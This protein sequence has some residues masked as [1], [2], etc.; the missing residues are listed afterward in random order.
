MGLFNVGQLVLSMEGEAR[1]D[2]SVYLAFLTQRQRK[3]PG[4]AQ[5][6]TG[7]PQDAFLPT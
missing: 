3:T 4:E 6:D 5:N 1:I 7:K 2:P